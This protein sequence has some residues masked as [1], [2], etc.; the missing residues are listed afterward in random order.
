MSVPFGRQQKIVYISPKG[1]KNN[2]A[3]P[4]EKDGSYEIG[5][6]ISHFFISE[7]YRNLIFG[8]KTEHM[9]CGRSTR[10]D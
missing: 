8:G 2:K 3:D 10:K 5:M 6:K 4:V 9:F 1:A 7:N